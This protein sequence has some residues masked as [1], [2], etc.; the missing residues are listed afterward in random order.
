[1]LVNAQSLSIKKRIVDSRSHYWPALLVFL[2]VVLSMIFADNQKIQYARE[3]LRNDA[4]ERLSV[5]RNSLEEK[6]HSNIYLMR[7]LVAALETEP[8]MT[9][10]RFSD[11]SSRLMRN[12]SELRILAAAPDFVV[13]LIY[14][15]KSNEKSIGLDYRKNEKQRT[16]ALRVQKEAKLVITGPV[17]LVQGGTGLIARYPVYQTNADGE[18]RFWGILS[19]VIDLSKLY[20]NA[21]LQSRE[22]KMEVA[23]ASMNE[24]GIFN[25]P[26]LGKTSTFGNNPIL[27]D[28]NFGH[29]KW[30]IAA[31]PSEGWDQLPSDIGWFRFFL[32]LAGAAVIAPMIWAG[33]LMAERE[34]HINVLQEREDQLLALSHRLQVALETSRIGVWEHHIDS[35]ELI[36]DERMRDLYDIDPAKLT[37]NTEDWSNALHPDDREAAM[38]DFADSLINKNEYASEFR[39]LTRSGEIRHIRAI[40]SR[41]TD[42]T[43][44]NK[45]VGVNLNVTADVRLR[46]ELGS[47]KLQAEQQ[48]RELELARGQ[49]EYNALHDSLTKLPN[50]RYLD[51]I[52]ANPPG[53][54]STFGDIAIL[55]IDLDRFKEI[56]D[57][58]GH[59]AGDE[60][61]RH[62]ARI[63]ESCISPEDFV[64]RIGGDE[65]VVI[66]PCG[67]DA[68][69]H[70]MLAAN[71][72]DAV[73]TP[74]IYDG[75]EC[76]I[77]VSIGIALQS[78]SGEDKQRL[79]I[80]ADIALYEAK[81]RGRNRFEY[82]TASLGTAVVTTKQT[83]DDILRGLEN[84][85]F[86]AYYQ[87]QFDVHSLQIT[88]VEALVRWN[89]PQKGLLVPGDFLAIAENLNVMARIDQIILEK[90]LLQ[91][92]RWEA[93]GLAIPK[94]S[95]NISAQRIR[96]E[97][98]LERLEKLPIRPG[99]LCFELL[100][101]I[102][103][104]END[105]QLIDNIA[106]IK[107]MGIE[108]EI[109]DFGT[110]Y[111]SIV[112]L[113]K[114]SPRRL[115][116]DR[117]L[118]APLLQSPAQQ[119]LVASIIDIGL[120]RGMEIIAEGVESLGHVAILRDLGCHSLQGYAFARPMSGNDFIQFAKK[121]AWPSQADVQS[122]RPKVVL[123]S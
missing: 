122:F 58:M 21:G 50:R 11:L 16:A 97:A 36:W 114:L 37:C 84:N 76:R 90:A 83:A 42:S 65:F 34:S 2:I 71:I 24:T 118:I 88:G 86:V 62:A 99:T 113:L 56:N 7:G 46:D 74:L 27:M 32:L 107:Q 109:D 10:T 26:F 93:A 60:I 92:V 123:A 47:A 63:L 17:D 94:V 53:E 22:L 45:I 72:I 73:K 23:I 67:G 4:T 102:S 33:H 59:G 30:M 12:D 66:S 8:D 31:V 85:E 80:N 81:R 15:V 5:L 55:H 79:L 51:Q 29:E 25:K 115:K 117:Q 38:A 119:Q 13:K 116:I 75:H 95:V 43:G 96:D 41:F 120:S 77:S 40:G 82:F 110:G 100:E 68:S 106:L 87:P 111:A 44:H 69:K 105:Q 19:G 52:L 1:M 3:G 9:Q 61:L 35:G 14:P 49:M 98:L 91:F 28:I 121:R 39:I 89:H 104:D 20:A 103:F 48:N 64:A 54:N 78:V 6:I 101:S 57:T 70:G 18:P 112:S 108:I